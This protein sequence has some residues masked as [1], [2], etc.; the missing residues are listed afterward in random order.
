MLL[1]RIH[2]DTLAGYRRARR[3]DGVSAGTINKELSCVHRVLNLAKPGSG[4][5]DSGMIVFWMHFRRLKWE[6]GTRSQI[7]S[8]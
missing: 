5:H 8:V 2:S 1:D 6:A 7:Q 3:A 4:E